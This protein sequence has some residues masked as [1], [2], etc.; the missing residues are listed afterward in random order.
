LSEIGRSLRALGRLNESE[1]PTRD[2]LAMRAR[3]FGDEHREVATNKYDL[4][5][6][7]MERGDIAEAE[8]MFR[9]SLATNERVLGPQHANTVAS[10]NAVGSVLAVKGDLVEAEKLQREVLAVRRRIF[11]EN[12]PESAFA[13]TSLATTLEMSARY[14]EA[15]SLLAG[16]YTTVRNTLGADHPGVVSLALDLARVRIARGGAA[17]VEALARPALAVRQRIYPAGHWRIAEAQALLGAS[18]AAQGRTEEAM[19]LMSAADQVFAPIPG[20]QAR[21]RDANRARLEQLRRR[22]VATPP[23]H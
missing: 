7:L 5:L 4:G 13:V 18:L 14:A 22:R 1:G 16:A 8:R 21:D 15:E 10:R 9:D 11:G 12:N 20:R 17:G 3:L 23:R 6:L 19:T 2:A